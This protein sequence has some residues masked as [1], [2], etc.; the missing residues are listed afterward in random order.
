[1][2]IEVDD[3]YRLGESPNITKKFLRALVESMCFVLVGKQIGARED[4]GTIKATI[5]QKRGILNFYGNVVKSGD[6][7]IVQIIDMILGY[8]IQESCRDFNRGKLHYWNI[9]KK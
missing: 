8:Y 2:N 9:F 3:D 7:K 1:M 6:S 4:K 5:K